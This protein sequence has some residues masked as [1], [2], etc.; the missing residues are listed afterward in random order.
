MSH[1]LEVMKD[2]RCLHDSVHSRLKLSRRLHWR[3]CRKAF[4]CGMFWCSL[5]KTITTSDILITVCL[6]R[7]VDKFLNSWIFMCSVPELTQLHPKAEETKIK[8]LNA[9]DINNVFIPGV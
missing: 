2:T 3:L 4:L 9:N 5:G 8:L 7:L 6:H 1:L